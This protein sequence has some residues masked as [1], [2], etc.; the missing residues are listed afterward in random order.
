MLKSFF[1]SKLLII[2]LICLTVSIANAQVFNDGHIIHMKDAN[3]T[4]TD[5]NL[6]EIGNTSNLT[7][8]DLFFR[9]TIDNSIADGT[10]INVVPLVPTNQTAP[11]PTFHYKNNNQ[12]TALQTATSNGIVSIK[13]SDLK[14][15]ATAQST[16]TVEVRV[17]FTTVPTYR[18]QVQLGRDTAATNPSNSLDRVYF[19]CQTGTVS[20]A[21]YDVTNDGQ[22][23]ASDIQAVSVAMLNNDLTGDVSEDGRINYVDYD[24]VTFAVG[25][26]ASI[27]STN[28]PPV[29]GKTLPDVE[30]WNSF[31]YEVYAHDHF[32]DPDGDALTYTATTSDSTIAS[33]VVGGVGNST[34]SVQAN[35]LGTATITI[36]VTDTKKASTTGTFTA[37]VVKQPPRAIGTIPD[38]KVKVEGTTTVDV[39]SYFSGPDNETLT[40][41]AS[42][43][44]TAKATVSV[45]SATVTI[46]GVAAGTATITVTGTARN[47]LTANQTFSAKVAANQAPVKS[48]KAEIPKQSISTSE[49]VSVTGID[50]YFTDPDGDPLTYTAS[51]SDTII[52]TVS[53]SGTTVTVSRAAAASSGQVTITVTATDPGGLSATRTFTVTVDALQDTTEASRADVIP[54]LSSEELLQLGALLTYNTVIINELHNASDDTTDWL[55][56]QNIS[57]VDLA[58]DDWQL[59]IQTGDDAIVV[60]FPAGTVIPAGEVL[61]LT[62]TKIATADLSVA[63]VVAETFVLPQTDFALILRSPTVFSD[64]V[65]NYV[66]GEA[67]RPETA[68]ALT[69]DTVWERTQPIVFGYRAEAWAASTSEDGLGTPGYRHPAP[70]VDLNNDGI[71]NILDLVRVA[72]QIGQPA[73]GNPADVNMDGVIDTADLLLVADGLGTPGYRHPAPSVDLNNDGIVNILDLVR[74]AGQIGQPATGNPADVNMDGVIDTADLLLV[75]EAFGTI[76]AN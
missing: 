47:G 61:L 75:A 13:Y 20:R 37:T 28:N 58:L 1:N 17:R 19:D 22:I 62:N 32:S 23:N 33:V 49:T 41:T 29:L 44:D 71:V 18:F 11:T 66:E 46:T 52:A 67:E 16:T 53:V 43:S 34:V 63:P 30:I 8:L 68:P 54:G 51:S 14:T 15:I 45:S 12:W 9:V 72:G 39:S 25:Q 38:Q 24:L 21:V 26:G 65:G 31:T 2:A 5:A 42:S 27:A 55:E 10:L 73:T 3:G 6:V 59:T 35:A 48:S 76:T 57:A 64:L 36:T 4:L 50:T 56:L 40:Y 7:T 60:P 69:V 70:S 74:V